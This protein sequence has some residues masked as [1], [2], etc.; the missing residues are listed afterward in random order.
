MAVV[1]LAGVELAA[2]E[3]VVELELAGVT[4]TVETMA[5]NH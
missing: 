3:L 1:E 4:V 2:V 5:A